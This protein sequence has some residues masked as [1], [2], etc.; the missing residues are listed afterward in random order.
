MSTYLDG[1]LVIAD[2]LLVVGDVKLLG[3]GNIETVANN[4]LTL[5]PNGSGI[6]IVGDAGS[7]GFL[8]TPTNDDMF[9]AGRFEADGNAYFD[10]TVRFSVPP[11]LP[12]DIGLQFGTSQ[13]ARIEFDTNQT[14]DSWMFGVDA[15]GRMLIVCEKADI[16]TDFGHAAEVNPT[17][18]IQSADATTPAQNVYL[19]H[20]Q[21]DG[22]LGCEAGDLIL[23]LPANKTLELSQVV[24]DDLRVPLE[25][26]QIAGGNTPTWTQFKDNGAA[27]VG[28]FAY[29]FA[30]QAVAGNEEEV[31][32]SAH[33]PHTYKQGTDLKFHV[34]WS[35]AV[36]GGLNEFVKWGLEYTW[37]NIDGTFG[38]TAIAT[39][40]ASSGATA[41]TSGDTT[42]TA[43]KHYLTEIATITGTSKNIGSMLICRIFRNSSDATDDLAQAAF[44]FEADFHFQVDTLGS[45]QEYVK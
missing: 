19:Q 33:M 37:V 10:G 28:V 16:P 21:T 40:D 11:Y 5:L 27:S 9:I 12:D 18:R 39:S 34:H 31:F 1:Q 8:G 3:G 41:T 29:S 13:D 24:W 7:P 35:P 14:V 43:D 44:A 2:D 4:D 6:T 42:L 32:F 23:T 15:V 20:N 25:R 22:I 26:G 38:N 36:S 17:V 30:D 45:R